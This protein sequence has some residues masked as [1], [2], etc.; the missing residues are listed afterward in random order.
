MEKTRPYSEKILITGGTSGLGLELAKLYLKKGYHV[1]AL[2][3]R[4]VQ[5]DFHGGRFDI[6]NVDFT[7]LSHTAEEIKKILKTH[8]F[9][10][11]INNAAVIGPSRYCMTVNGFELTF[12][13]NFLSHLLVNE[14]LIRTLCNHRP[15]KII[16]VTSPVHRIID[17]EKLFSC[18]EEPGYSPLKAYSA[19]KLCLIIMCSFLAERYPDPDF[20]F[21]S[22]S[23]G[24]FSSGIFRMQQPFLRGL[25]KLAAPFM[26]SPASEA[27]EM[28]KIIGQ[29]YLTN[30]Y[31][32]FRGKKQPGEVKIS[33][34][35][36]DAFMEDCYRT[37]ED[38]LL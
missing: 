23:P 10:T 32:Y 3:R 25:Y 24:V 2:G 21:I 4:S 27:D 22:Y 30:G 14:I 15:L 18:F 1:V 9:R 37:I 6:Y 19:S 31:V 16:A 13:V 29:N 28:L 20:K 8:T 38:F 12:Q 36:C 7:D 11:V 17:P 35:L 34:A 26:K 33:K 5:T